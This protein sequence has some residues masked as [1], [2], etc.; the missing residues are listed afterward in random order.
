MIK[1]IQILGLIIL[2][3][4]TSYAQIGQ[5][6]TA[7]DIGGPK[8]KGSSVY[9][10]AT[11]TYTLKGGGENI[12][13]NH[14]EFHFL[15]KKIK[16]DFVLTANFELIGN[17]DGNDHRKTGWMIRETTEPD[18]VSIN[19][20]IHG[21]GLAVLQWRV[22]PGAYMRDPEEEI[23]FPKQYFGETIIQLERI[24]KTITM[25][26]AHPG[27]PLE[28]MGSMTLPELKDEVLVGPYA[29]AHDPNDIQE[30]RVWNVSITTP[31]APEW[32]PNPLVKTMSHEGL[33]MPSKIEIIDLASRKRQVIHTSDVLLGAPY[34]SENGNNVLFAQ[35]AKTFELPI[36]G[37]VVEEAANPNKII[38]KK[39][40]YIYYSEGNNSTN[41]IWRKKLDGSDVTQM[42]H[43]LD[44]ARFPHV[45][46]N[47]KWVTYI[48]FPHDSNPKEPAAFQSV[49]LKIL[50]TD[51]GSDKTIA[52]FI[53]GKGSFEN[54]AWSPDS[55]SLVFQS[56][57]E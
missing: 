31:M 15:F 56:N 43:N 47:G 35:G 34:F 24:G 25:R 22:M 53:G 6:E 28:D 18:A 23:F 38:S 11:Q 36:K 41:Q 44:H 16:G 13:F 54:Y 42:T 39:G 8:I 1:N 12:W 51:G 20:C 37:G 30:A 50:P 14:D 9:D 2:S 40:K 32:H 7:L 52:Y 27:E 57:G 49:T 55:K 21:D 29:L 26:V 48:S 19:S 3:T 5:F 4:Y 10:E 45:S 33:E 46:P 17:E